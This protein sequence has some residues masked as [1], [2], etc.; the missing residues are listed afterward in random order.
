MNGLCQKAPCFH[1]G[2]LLAR[3]PRQLV[4]LNLVSDVGGAALVLKQLRSL[5]T[6]TIV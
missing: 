1:G 6:R 3:L 5:N 4:G 2:S